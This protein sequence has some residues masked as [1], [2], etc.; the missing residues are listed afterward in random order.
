M[1]HL[2]ISYV[3]VFY[4]TINL[5]FHNRMQFLYSDMKYTSVN[6]FYAYE[7]KALWDIVRVFNVMHCID[8]LALVLVFVYWK[9]FGKN[10]LSAKQLFGC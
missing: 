4:N 10:V 2:V 1:F 6:E 8:V 3:S 5:I 9:I 7:N